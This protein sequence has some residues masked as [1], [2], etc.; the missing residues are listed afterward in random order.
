MIISEALKPL[1]N[2]DMPPVPSEPARDALATLQIDRSQYAPRRTWRAWRRRFAIV[3]AILLFATLAWFGA[4]RAGWLKSGSA[5]SGSWFQ[6]PDII[7][8]RPEVRIVRPVVET[9]RAADATVVATGYLESRRQAKIGARAPGRIQEVL[10]EEGS[11]VTK[12][13][14]LAV[15]EHADLDASLAAAEASLVRARAAIEEQN[16]LI[17][18]NKRE[19]ERAKTLLATRSI[20]DNEHD[21]AK[22]Q[23][24]SS[25]A[26]LQS[27]KADVQLAEARQREAEQLKENMFIRAP[28]D[29]TVIS[30]DAEVGESIL[31][32]GMGEA[33]GRGSAVTI[34][35]L[36]NLEV[37]C[38]VKEDYISRIVG[39]QRTEV[40]VDAVPDRRYHGVVRKVIPMGD[41]ARA[42]IKVKVTITD[43]DSRLFPDMSSTVYFLPAETA[44]ETVAEVPRTFCPDNALQKDRQG[45]FVW[46]IDSN[47]HAQKVRVTSGR[48]KDGRVEILSGLAGDER[49]IGNPPSLEV[50]QA[51]KIT[52]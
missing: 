14:V 23:F 34:A 45:E 29:G 25:V 44:G 21:Q 47:S 30:K 48:R 8:S 41:R 37:D 35:D 50:D 31:P 18:Q 12:D 36:D 39:G 6:V 33:S 26:R 40:A 3:L 42:T 27:M 15:L 38:D 46:V 9:G 5:G 1:E 24:D 10:V 17:A 16:V 7:K 43:V 11:R 13:Q 19:Y 32:G 2:V 4:T 20:S 22:F 51:V 28:F 52:E 49:I